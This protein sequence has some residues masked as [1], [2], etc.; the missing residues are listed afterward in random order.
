[1]LHIFVGHTKENKILNTYT[2]GKYL[3]NDLVRRALLMR[4][5]ASTYSMLFGTTRCNC[6][7]GVPPRVLHGSCNRYEYH[8][9]N[10]YKY[11]SNERLIACIYV[12]F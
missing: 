12:H 7:L 9:H 5:R 6:S 3:L 8:V 10:R 2:K 1:M 11:L 4:Y